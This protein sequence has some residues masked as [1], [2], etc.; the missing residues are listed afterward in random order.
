MKPNT[1]IASTAIL[2]VTLVSACNMQAS[3]T[4]AAPATTLAPAPAANPGPD[5]S[6]APVERAAPPM[7]EP[8]AL[9]TFEPGNPV[10]VAGTGKLT[11]V[12][13]ALSGDNGARFTTER[14]AIASGSD[15]YRPGETYADVMFIDAGHPVELRRVIE[16]VPPTDV[17]ENAFCG[18]T[19]TDY[20]ALAK[21]MEDTTEV[22][23]LIA[24]EGAGLPSATATGTRLCAATNYL[25]LGE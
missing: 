21:V 16:Q 19:A 22:V 12:D 6:A 7:L 15:E 18:N 24:L 13:D 8:V 23:K 25:I 3:G 2:A 5:P 17:R 10:A 9:G 11:I 20:I 14:V 4:T 1:V